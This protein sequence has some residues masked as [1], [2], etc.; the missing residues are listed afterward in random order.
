ME[1]V[2]MLLAHA[3][4]AAAAQAIDDGT[5]VQ[6]V[7]YARLRRRLLQDGMLLDW[8]PPAGPL[9]IDGPALAPGE[10]T[11]HTVTLHNEEGSEITDVA[12]ALTAPGEWQAAASTPTTFDRVAALGSVVA[13]WGLTAPPQ[14]EPVTVRELL[15]Q[16]TYTAEGRQVTRDVRGPAYVVEPVHD[17]YRTFA[18]TRA[19]QGQRGGRFGIMASGA[20]LWTGADE[21]GA[22]YLRGAAGQRSTAIT[23][24]I[25]Q[26]PTDPNARA[27]LMM[28]DDITLAGRSHGYVVLAVKPQHGFLLLWDADGN[29]FVDSVARADTGATPYPAWLRLDRDHST[30]TGYYSLDGS[31]WKPIGQAVVP[32]AAATQDAGIFATSHSE[33]LGRVIFDGFQVTAD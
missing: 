24:I 32:S 2:F 12:L 14:D 1:P 33:T 15:A 3:A 26:D 19:Y 13:T 29:G 8:P 11:P 31:I 7:D 27:G 6:A 16:A 20:D 28:R 17:P 4:A 5:S 30:Y 10:S 23:K 9:A 25:S 21:Y 18:S 22:I